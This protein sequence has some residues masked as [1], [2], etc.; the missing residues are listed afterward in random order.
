MPSVLHE[1]YPGSDDPSPLSVATIDRIRNS[2]IISNGNLAVLTHLARNGLIVPALSSG[3]R[4]RR[5]PVSTGRLQGRTVIPPA[6]TPWFH[7]F[8]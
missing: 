8:C 4:H 6:C 5:S 2:T 3:F 1:H 7:I